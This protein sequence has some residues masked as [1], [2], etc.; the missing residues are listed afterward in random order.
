M[1]RE[2]SIETYL[3]ERVKVAGGYCIKLN[4]MGNVGIPDRLVL[5]PEGVIVFVECKKPRGGVVSRAQTRW[6]DRLLD[7]G[8]SHRFVWTRADVDELLEVFG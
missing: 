8:L 5:L 7:M 4:P 3:R 1:T 2:S 6:R